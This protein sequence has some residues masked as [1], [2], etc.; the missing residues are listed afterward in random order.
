MATATEMTDLDGVYEDGRWRSITRRYAIEGAT[1]ASGTS[2]LSEMRSATGVPAY[3]STVSIDGDTLFARVIR[4]RLTQS[5]MGYVDVTFQGLDE[6][7]G[8]TGGSSPQISISGGLKMA[9]RSFDKDDN[10]IEV[11]YTWPTGSTEVYPDGTPKAGTTETQGGVLSVPVPSL[12]ANAEI[13]VVTSAPGTFAEKYAGKVNS[14]TWQSKP[15]RTW[16]C[17][18]GD[19]RQI[20]T[21]PETHVF[22]VSFEYEPRTWDHDHILRFIN[23]STGQ[24]VEGATSGDGWAQQTMLDEVDFNDDF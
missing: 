18:L 16:L 12:I 20:A 8:V 23:P 19:S 21:S 3:G 17:S 6:S 14:A 7:S 5:D 1:G 24:P 10:P 11:S 2:R 4:P 22:P 15:A 9:E 13:V